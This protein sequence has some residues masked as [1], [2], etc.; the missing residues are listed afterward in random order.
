MNIIK[1]KK[2]STLVL[3]V[4]AIG[5]ISLLGTSV[6]AVTMMNYK[7]KKANTELKSTFYL[8]ESGL[9]KA[10]ERAYKLVIEGIGEGNKDA[11]TF[12]KSVEEEV[13]KLKMEDTMPVVTLGFDDYVKVL[14]GPENSWSINVNSIAVDDKAENIYNNS[15]MNFLNEVRIRNILEAPYDDVDLDVQ[16]KNPDEGILWKNNAGDM[17]MKV[18]VNSRFTKDSGISKTTST[19]LLFKVP[20]YNKPYSVAM[21]HIDKHVLW[22]NALWAD[23]VLLT[24]DMFVYGNTYVSKNFELVSANSNAEVK[25]ELIVKGGRNVAEDDDMGIIINGSNSSLK[26]EEGDVYTKNILLQKSNNSFNANKDVY[27]KDDLE[28]N[29][30]NQKVNI[31]GSYYGFSFGGAYSTKNTANSAIIINSPDI[32]WGGSSLSIGK[33]L[34]LYGVSYIEG[35]E[36][37]TGESVS[38]IGN[39]GV[40][41]QYLQGGESEGNSLKWDKIHFDDSISSLPP[42]AEGFK[43][44]EENIIPMSPW[45][46]ADYF[47]QYNKPSEYNGIGLNLGGG[48]ITIGGSLV[49]TLGVAIDNNYIVPTAYNF[50][51]IDKITD[52]SKFL[53][54]YEAKTKNYFDGVKTKVEAN[55]I[56]KQRGEELIYIDNDGIV[57]SNGK[58]NSKEV[59]GGIIVTNGNVEINGSLS[60][61]GVIISGGEVSVNMASGEKFE[62]EYDEEYIAK[63]VSEYKLDEDL[64]VGSDIDS[65]VGLVDIPLYEGGSSDEIIL[66]NYLYFENWKIE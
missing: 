34:S 21:D 52:D 30:N 55:K 57:I 19:E 40:Y 8:S 46:K 36:Y 64:F 11:E 38:I 48:H 61:K 28:M 63:L 23:S 29:N 42:L 33:N 47:V 35:T 31:D 1:N 14:P 25:G 17:V 26:V 15:Y 5:V 20:P 9:D 32:A 16:V 45:H 56:N 65:V 41:T 27:V 24:G 10:Y 4:I 60:F 53:Q 66:E 22:A 13:E 43:V 6:L 2:G 50:S 7:I 62:L 58:Y 54:P 12:I 44:T 3:L 18:K 49:E 39:Y 59:K 37:A 51:F